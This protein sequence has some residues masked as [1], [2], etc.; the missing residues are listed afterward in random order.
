MADTVRLSKHQTLRIVSSTPETLEVESTWAPHGDPP[1]RH[2]HPDQDERFEILEGELTV[3]LAD[4]TQVIAAGKQIEVPRGTVHRMWN[5]GPADRA[6]WRVTPARRTEEMFRYIDAG[7]SPVR[8]IRM[9][10]FATSSGND[11]TALISNW[12]KCPRRARLVQG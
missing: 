7:L 11:R 9:L 8:T 12:S 10:C 4:V 5:A 6:T 3:E 1:Q 2:F